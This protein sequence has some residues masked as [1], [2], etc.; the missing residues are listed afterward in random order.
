MKKIKSFNGKKY[1]LVFF[2]SLSSLSVANAQPGDP[3]TDPDVPISGIE[4]LIGAGGIIGVKKMLEKRN[5][6][7]K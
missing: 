3:G 4:V 6:K 1:L 2:I 5:K 7:N